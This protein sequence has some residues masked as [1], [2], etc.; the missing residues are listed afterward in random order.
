MYEPKVSKTSQ[1]EEDNSYR[2]TSKGKLNHLLG[3]GP[4][5]GDPKFDAWDEEDSM[6]QN[7]TRFSGKDNQ[8][9]DN[10]WC[11]YCKKPRHTK[12]RCWKLH[13]KPSTSS[14]EWGY[15]GEQSKTYGQ[16]HLTEQDNPPE[17]KEQ[18]GL[19]GEEIERLRGLI[20]SLEKPSGACSLAL[21]GTGFEEEDWTC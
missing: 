20:G 6:I 16:A 8:D 10:L 9:R 2:P 14:K 4:K 18:E 7:L 21:S 5:Q 1:S 17:K 3:T 13:G 11:T 15:R 12:D 19:S